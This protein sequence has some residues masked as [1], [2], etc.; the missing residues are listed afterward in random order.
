MGADNRLISIT[1]VSPWRTISTRSASA[2][3]QPQQAAVSHVD[4][5]CARQALADVA[6]SGGQATHLLQIA[7][8]ID[9]ARHGLATYAQRGGQLR[10]IEQAALHLGQQGQ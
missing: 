2:P 8:D 10:L 9:L 7:E 5:G 1:Q 6:M 3:F 4:L